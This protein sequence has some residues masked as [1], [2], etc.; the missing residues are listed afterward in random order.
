[1]LSVGGGAHWRLATECQLRA[2][3]R[4]TP[5]KDSASLTHR[6]IIHPSTTL[7][8]VAFLAHCDFRRSNGALSP[9][10]AVSLP[11]VGSGPAHS[12][13]PWCAAARCA[14]PETNRK[15]RDG[16]WCHCA[17]WRS[18][19]AATA[20]AIRLPRSQSV[21][22]HLKTRLWKVRGSSGTEQRCSLNQLLDHR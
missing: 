18:G 10:S 14:G 5:I 9:F 4:L 20:G 2:K 3:F 6:S 13:W 17:P 1:M 19:E 8:P 7:R 15:L 22:P 11:A 16:V 21:S 12:Q